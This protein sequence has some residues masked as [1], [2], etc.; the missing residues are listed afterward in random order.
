MIPERNSECR[1]CL[2]SKPV[3]EDVNGRF[4]Q[5]PHASN[6]EGVCSGSWFP[7]KKEDVKSLD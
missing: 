5:A 3:N 7:V 6:V 4:Y 1:I 2:E